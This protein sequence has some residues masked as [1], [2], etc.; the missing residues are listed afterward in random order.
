MDQYSAPPPPRQE[1]SQ[2]QPIIIKQIARYEETT[3]YPPLSGYNTPPATP[4]PRQQKPQDQLIYTIS[5]S[6]EQTAERF[7]DSLIPA[8]YEESPYFYAANYQQTQT[9]Y[10]AENLADNSLDYY[11][12]LEQNPA[13]YQQLQPE[14]F[15]QPQTENLNIEPLDQYGAVGMYHSRNLNSALYSYNE[16]LFR[17][18][19]T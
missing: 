12:N 16:R 5:E 9:E 18:I 11:G 10:S 17:K 4:P 8:D 6:T 3:P 1:N 19:L 7:S 13:N 2:N 14:K 15:E